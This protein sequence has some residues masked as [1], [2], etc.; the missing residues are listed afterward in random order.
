[1][2][3]C[4]CECMVKVTNILDLTR[5]RDER[6]NEVYDIPPGTEEVILLHGTAVRFIDDIARGGVK[7][8]RLT[9][10]NNWSVWDIPSNPDFTYWGDREAARKYAIHCA[11]S[12]GGGIVYC[13]ARFRVEDLL[14]DE[15]M[16]KQFGAK[17][18]RESLAHG[19]C[20]FNGAVTSLTNVL[21]TLSG[22]YPIRTEEIKFM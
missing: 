7:P 13:Q 10:N 6:G 17:D 9:G 11:T 5:K 20:A 16:Q 19:T 22:E 2:V 15:E 12:N 1:M 3:E 8:E 14:P 18:W 4:S 21:N